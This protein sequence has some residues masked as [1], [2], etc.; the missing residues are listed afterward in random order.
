MKEEERSVDYVE[1]ERDIVKKETEHLKKKKKVR[2][3]IRVKGG[4]ENVFFFNCF[5]KKGKLKM[6]KK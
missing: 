6:I 5:L 4:F 2:W 3:K 1:R